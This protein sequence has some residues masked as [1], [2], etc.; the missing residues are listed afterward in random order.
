MW[1]QHKNRIESTSTV[2]NFWL[3]GQPTPC[4]RSCPLPNL[5]SVCSRKAQN[6]EAGLTAPHWMNSNGSD[7]THSTTACKKYTIHKYSTVKAQMYV[8]TSTFLLVFLTLVYV[9]EPQYLAKSTLDAWDLRAFGRHCI[10][11]SQSSSKMDWGR[12]ENCSVIRQIE[13]VKVFLENMSAVSSRLKRKGTI[14]AFYQ[15]SVQ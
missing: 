1:N 3:G 13:M 15:H 9:R 5:S 6:S 11:N 14:P 7:C 10:K 2:S 8:Q 4:V 12:E